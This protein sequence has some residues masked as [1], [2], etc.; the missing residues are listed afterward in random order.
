MVLLYHNLIIIPHFGV[1]NLARWRN[2]VNSLVTI[3]IGVVDESLKSGG[4]LGVE[5]VVFV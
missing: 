2:D 3:I 1:I 4:D 5:E